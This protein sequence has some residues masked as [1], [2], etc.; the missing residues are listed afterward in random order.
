MKLFKFY[1]GDDMV[2]EGYFDDIDDA[3]VEAGLLETEMGLKSHSIG[4][5]Q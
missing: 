5:R 3:I 4:V 2:S 1:H